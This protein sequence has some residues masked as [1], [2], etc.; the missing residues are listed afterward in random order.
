MRKILLDD[1]EYEGRAFNVR[2]SLAAVLFSEPR[3]APREVIRR[4]E[5]A[6]KIENC[7]E[8]ILLLEEAEYL[9]LVTGLNASDLAPLGRA[10]VPFV[11]RILD[12]PE[13]EVQEKE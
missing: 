12:A 3:L 2:P 9:K 4:D 11:K 8:P 13:I 7:P 6:V 10:V 1:Y 5:L